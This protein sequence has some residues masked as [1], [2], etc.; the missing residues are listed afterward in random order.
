MRLRRININVNSSLIFI[1]LPYSYVLHRGKV[2]YQN[3]PLSSAN[4]RRM[5]LNNI[6]A[7]TITVPNKF[8]LL[9]IEN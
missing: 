9:K 3:L 7:T 5:Y 2:K 6:G 1:I 8:T 4:E